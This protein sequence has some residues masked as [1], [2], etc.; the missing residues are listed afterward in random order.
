MKF[1]LIT[2]CYN[3]AETICHTLQS[4]REQTYPNIEYI[5]VDGG[6]K[7][8]TLDLIAAEGPHVSK[9]ISE[10]DNGIY[11]A[12]N[13]GLALATG[14]VVGFLNSDDIFYGVDVISKIARAMEDPLIGACYGDL[15]Y[16][17]KFDKN[18]IIRYWKSGKYELG[19]CA[20]GWMPPH[21][22]FY[23]R[24]SVYQRYGSFDLSLKLQADFEM[25]LRLLDIAHI[26]TVYLPEILV[27]MRVGGA[28]NASLKNIIKGNIEAARA[29][30]K[31]GLPGGLGFVGKKIISRIPQFFMRPQFHD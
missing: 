1:S 12:M 29:C 24:R 3:S 22:T 6:S 26:R 17:S 7:D 11:D 15:V 31:H 14:D 10:R 13:K 25:A 23:T 9:L 4:V 27:R 19:L 18:K 28:S 2:V 20:R 30:R 21:P 5:I 16:V 8:N